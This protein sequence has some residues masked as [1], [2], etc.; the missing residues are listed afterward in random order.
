MLPEA[1]YGGLPPRVGSISTLSNCGAP[2]SRRRGCAE[3]AAH[4]ARATCSSV[5]AS[6]CDG[7]DGRAPRIEAAHCDELS[8]SDAMLLLQLMRHNIF[9]ERRG[10]VPVLLALYLSRARSI[11]WL[12]GAPQPAC[13]KTCLLCV[14]MPPQN[15]AP[16]LCGA[17]DE[18]RGHPR[19]VCSEGSHDGPPVFVGRV[20]AL[21]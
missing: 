12:G 15:V 6:M 3:V 9:D 14:T 20:R 10:H 18:S 4:R 7:C 21:S 17:I 1:G 5:A 11:D 13:E 8:D 19:S 16:Q 2:K